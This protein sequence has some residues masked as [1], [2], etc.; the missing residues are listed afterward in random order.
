MNLIFL[1]YNGKVHCSLNYIIYISF[2]SAGYV[3]NLYLHNLVYFG[4]TCGLKQD[5]LEMWPQMGLQLTA[6]H[7]AWVGALAEWQLVGENHSDYR[8]FCTSATLPT[9]NS[10]KTT[11]ELNPSLCSDNPGTKNLSHGM[12]LPLTLIDALIKGFL[13]VRPSLPTAENDGIVQDI[14]QVN[15]HRSSL[16]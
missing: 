16:H 4:C 1:H 10:T 3:Y 15:I 8:K 13:Q 2:W 7:D 14:H 9:I 12:A 5:S 11:V 6:Q